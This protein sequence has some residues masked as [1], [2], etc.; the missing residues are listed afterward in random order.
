MRNGALIR[1]LSI[2]RMLEGGGRYQ[3]QQLAAM[4]AVHPRTIRRDLYALETAGWPIGHTP[5]D[6]A[7]G[8]PGQWWL[9]DRH[10]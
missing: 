1:A 9:E 10:E 4:F 5:G 8:D 7:G 6:S 3:L 2:I